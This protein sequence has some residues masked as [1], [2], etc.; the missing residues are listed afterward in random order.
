M[1]THKFQ[2]FSVQVSMFLGRTLLIFII[3]AILR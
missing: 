2:E 1:L 3:I